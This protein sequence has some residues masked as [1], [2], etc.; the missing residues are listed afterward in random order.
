MPTFIRKKEVLVE[1]Y[2]KGRTYSDKLSE[3]KN[4]LY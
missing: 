2:R 3:K 1:S 4:Y